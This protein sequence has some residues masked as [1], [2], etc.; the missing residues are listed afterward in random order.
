MALHAE[1][2][3]N[4]RL[5]APQETRNA[6]RSD[7]VYKPPS[8]LVPSLPSSKNRSEVRAAAR[9]V[10]SRDTGINFPAQT[11]S[12]SDQEV[13]IV[14]L[15]DLS[16]KP[17]DKLQD[18]KGSVSR[19]ALLRGAAGAG[20]AYG[21]ARVLAACGAPEQNSFGEVQPSAVRIII[22]SLGDKAQQVYASGKYE[23]ATAVK[24]QKDKPSMRYFSIKYVEDSFDQSLA[25][26]DNSPFRQLAFSVTFG[27]PAADY[28][29]IEKNASL[30]PDQ[31]NA[32][33]SQSLTDFSLKIVRN[34]NERTS[35]A[36]AMQKT[37]NGNWTN[38][39]SQL[40]TATTDNDILNTYPAHI[41]P[42]DTIR[43]GR[44]NQ[45]VGQVLKMLHGDSY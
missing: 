16:A 41:D 13:P 24:E 28:D 18:K 20:F 2:G 8:D 19:R 22:N 37:V 21:A 44:F 33:L 39:D 26:S 11:K 34:Q 15:S 27:L 5:P 40:D 9:P 6:G 23:T 31:R 35:L 25:P 3:A 30:T 14:I 32:L 4:R 29:K 1:F 43:L 7:L 12:D 38:S 17:T 10:P 42:L 45:A 36:M